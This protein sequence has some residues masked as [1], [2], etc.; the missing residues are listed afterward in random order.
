MVLLPTIHGGVKRDEGRELPIM[1]QDESAPEKCVK[2]R[3]DL[4]LRLLHMARG[5]ENPIRLNVIEQGEARLLTAM[6]LY[7]PYQPKY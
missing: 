4:G 3:S 7:L 2:M 1:Y 6:Y 5:P